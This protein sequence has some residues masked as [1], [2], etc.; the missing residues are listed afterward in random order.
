MKELWFLRNDCTY[1]NGKC[2]INVTKKRIM[3]GI[4]DSDTRMK[5][6]Q[7]SEDLDSQEAYFHLPS[8][9][10]LLL[11][12][13][14]ASRGNPSID[15]YGIVGTTY[16]CEFVVAISGGIGISTNLY[17]EVIAILVAG[18]WVVHNGFLELIFRTDSHA[19]KKAF[20]NKNLPWFA[21]TRWEK[22]CV[23]V[24]SWSFTHSYRETNFSADSMAKKGAV[25]NRGEQRIYTS[26]PAFLG[27]MESPDTVYFRFC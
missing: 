1:G 26:K 2:D 22:I 21:I 7:K 12:C 11:C 16:T 25:L 9:D 19:V 3:K 24:V 10:K 15:G 8:Q 27:C 5:A 23:A 6:Y 20:Y 17:A 4:S 13:D 18:E 14:G